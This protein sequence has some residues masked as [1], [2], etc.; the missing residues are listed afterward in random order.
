LNIDWQRIMYVVGGLSV[1]LGF[2]LKDL[3]ENF[4]CGLI[5]LVGKEIRPGDIVEFDG[6]WGVVTSLNIRC[7]FIRTFDNAVITLP[8][9]Q[10]VSKNFRNWTLNGHIMRHQMEIGVSYGTDVNKAAELLLKAANDCDMVMKVRDPEVLFVDFGDSALIFRLR[11]WL[12]IDNLSKAPSQI[13]RN[14]A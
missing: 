2:A 9:N 1:G 14:I 13:R 3:L 6:T 4:V 7:T 11:Y 5:L 8:N 10:V 12:H